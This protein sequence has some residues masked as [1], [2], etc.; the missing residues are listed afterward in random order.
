VSARM[1]WI[2]FLFPM[3]VL[4]VVEALE[5]SQNRWGGR[6]VKNLATN[7]TIPITMGQVHKRGL[8]VRPID[9]MD[10]VLVSL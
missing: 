3:T 2:Y 6:K 7:S 4:L 8:K 5:A 9:P 10:Y 1:E